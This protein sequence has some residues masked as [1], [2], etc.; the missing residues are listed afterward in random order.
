MANHPA[1]AMVRTPNQ[2]AFF[3]V[4]NDLEGRFFWSG[5]LGLHWLEKSHFDQLGLVIVQVLVEL[6]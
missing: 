3:L 5:D 6:H 1:L 4:R 2:Q